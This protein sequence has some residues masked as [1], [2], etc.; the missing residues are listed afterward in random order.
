MRRI[1]D[2]LLTTLVVLALAAANLA[3][4]DS[5][6][7]YLHDNA[8]SGHTHETLQLPLVDTWD[9]QPNVPPDPAWTVPA[10]EAARVRFDD[11][12]HVTSADGLVYFGSSGDNKVYALYADNGEVA[13]TFYTGGPVR[14]APAIAGD[15]VYVGSDDGLVY[16]LTADRGEL[17]W[18]RRIADADDRVIGNGR[19]ISLW[20]V[21]TSVLVDHGVAYAGA[22]VFPSEE[23]FIRALNAED[24]SVLWRNDDAGDRGPEQ[25]YD[26]ISPQGYLLASKTTLYVASGRSMPAAFGRADGRFRFYLSPGGKVG[27]TYALLADNQLIAGVNA[28]KVYD[29]KTGKAEQGG[30]AWAPAHRLIVD[31]DISYALDDHQVSALDR[32]KVPEVQ[33]E[34]NKLA[35]KRGIREKMV[36]RTY[37]DRFK[38]DRKATDYQQQ[39]DKLSAEIEQTLAEIK[40]LA[41]KQKKLESGAYLWQRKNDL[42]DAM[43]LAGK[44]LF[45]GGSGRVIAVD[46]ET[47][48]WQWTGTVQGRASGLA[49]CDGRLLVS[50]TAGT[51][52]C[53]EQGKPR[54]VRQR[55]QPEVKS[56]PYAKDELTAVY[57]AA[58]RQIVADSGIKKGFCL[59]L[60]C[61]KGRLALELA[62]RTEL[63]IYGIDP[64]PEN[65][66]AARRAIDAAGLYGK[67]VTIDSGPLD[68]LPY[69]GYCANLIVSDTALITGRLEVPAEELY[70]VLRPS[71][72]V[73]MLGQPANA[74]GRVESLDVKS[75]A[76]A[77]NRVKETGVL[78]HEQNRG[79]WILHRRGTLPGGG[80]WSHEYGNP[81][82]TANSNDV[83]L[84]APLGVVWFGPPGP[85]RMVE[86]HARAAAPLA[87]DGR[88][89]VQGENVV[90]C[91]DAYNGTK[92]WE[93]EIAGA[94]RVR[95]DVDGSNFAVSDKGLF[96]GVR[97]KALRLDPATGET[98]AEYRMPS[99]PDGKEQRWGALA[100]VGNTLYGT[101]AEPLAEEYGARWQNTT[102]DAVDNR[103]AFGAF[104]AGG[105]MW[106]FMQRWPDWG[107]EDSWKGSLTGRMIASDAFFALD[108][109][110][111]APRWIYHGK[112]SHSS[113]A[114]ADGVV[115]LAD[116]AVT[117]EQRKAA[118]AAR[119][120]R[121]GLL[122]DEAE[123]ID[124]YNIYDVRKLVALEDKTGKVL[125]QRVVDVTGSGGDKVGLMA[126]H[127]LLLVFG[128][129]SNHDGSQFS[130]GGLAWR[131]VTVVDAKDG[132][133][134][135]SKELNYL[136]RPFVIGDV[137]VVEPQAV[138]VA[139]GELVMR[140]HPITGEIVPWEFKRGGHSCG[141]C[142][143]SA[144]VF[145]LRSGSINY[146]DYRRDSGMLPIGGMRAGCWINMII[147]GG[148]A[149]LPEA[150]A[151][152]TCSFPI[153]S[154][155]AMAP[156]AREQTW[157]IF[158]TSAPL[159]PVKHWTIN[160]GAPGDR[161]DG[162]DRVWFSYPR[163]HVGYGVKFKLDE[164]LTEGGR[165]Y[166]TSPT[167]VPLENTDKPWIYCCGAEGLS[168]CALDLLD[169]DQGPATYTVRLG[170]CEP[171]FESAG[172][173][174]F[175]VKL[176]GQTVAENFDIAKTAGGRNRVVLQ[177]FPGI[178][179]QDKLV[180]ELAPNTEAADA[181]PLLNS[182]EVVRE[183]PKSASLGK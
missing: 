74:R 102:E 90:M 80:E 99:P 119:R 132:T 139:T 76:A 44:T 25:Q 10:K 148:M 134:R 63:N 101:D 21:R 100:T 6:P 161:K 36:R 95:V 17:V 145:F 108:V 121:Y 150:S 147:A 41:A 133:D 131:R 137:L 23:I 29:Q 179:V 176:Q 40:Q 38:L 67:R 169:A 104:N 127:G 130:K 174:V 153:R 88:L 85:E 120:K 45:I 62:R 11:A 61:G 118:V 46:A 8:R 128:H 170:F 116:A 86:R 173:R 105:G 154:T 138:D 94:V 166:A 68:R 35:R 30:Y 111:G 165:F 84:R 168:R 180:I 89:F 77:L 7:T 22:G 158:V 19:M 31:G 109:E 1:T 162:D 60:G 97:D 87:R 2:C 172:K 33:R 66:A 160:L 106:R 70:R 47:G 24:G 5:W 156:K 140:K 52:H 3:V 37:Y 50:T 58:A 81:A 51:I 42:R 181:R 149:L 71:G 15:K 92:L 53:F 122:S 72:G 136:R 114:I 55:V 171:K 115:Y 49:V 64:D 152:C 28:Q 48:Q 177:S 125:W 167:A 79:T 123:Q 110:T 143:A 73:V 65:V 32:S 135:W 27:G 155:I 157:S 43:I 117:P 4:A 93:R 126:Y 69:P 142:T 178:K 13:W 83:R 144:D 164:V 103:K 26:G 159:K 107:R 98:I 183:E 151:G 12:F 34:R 54:H 56:R 112:V 129:F 82:N 39:Y 96:V 59:V 182:I 18:K 20:P 75:I 91:Y 14:L 113:M 146:Y 57:A 9:F 16:C 141:I 175:D 163:L 124:N 78:E